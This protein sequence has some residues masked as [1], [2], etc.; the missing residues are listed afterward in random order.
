MNY[1][2][3]S[4]GP[5]AAALLAG[6]MMTT[7]AFAQ[8]HMQGGGGGPSSFGASGGSRVNTNN[9]NSLPGGSSMAYTPSQMDASGDVDPVAEADVYLAYGRDEQAEDILKEALHTH[10]GRAAI[11]AKLLEI[12]AKRRDTN[13]FESLASE[14]FKLTQGQGP[15]WAYIIELAK[16]AAYSAQWDEDLAYFVAAHWRNVMVDVQHKAESVGSQSVGSSSTFEDLMKH[17]R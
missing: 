9:G 6:V 15:E 8:H 17:D 16:P 3:K 1:R 2:T 11:H 12:Y 5:L 7:P 10:P 4:I 14:A 13:A